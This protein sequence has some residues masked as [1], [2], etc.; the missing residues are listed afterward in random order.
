LPLDGMKAADEPLIVELLG[1]RASE[2]TNHICIV[3]R[4][5]IRSQEGL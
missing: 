4:Y 2:R 5:T 1:I 3:S